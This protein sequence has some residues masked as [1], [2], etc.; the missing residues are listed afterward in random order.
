MSQTYKFYT[1]RADAAAAAAEAAILDN[2]RERELR[3]E[4]T[5]RR[6]A[7]QTQRVAEDRAKADAE[8]AERRAAE[9]EAAE[10]RKA[11]QEAEAADESLQ[12]A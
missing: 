5:W 6:L 12:E 2:V 8:R 10:E 1:E 4:E 11:A 3:A 7:E 9:A